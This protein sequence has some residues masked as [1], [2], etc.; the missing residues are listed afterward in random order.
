MEDQFGISGSVDC[1]RLLSFFPF[2][3]LRL[4]RVLKNKE[5]HNTGGW[6]WSTACF[7]TA[8]VSWMD[9]VSVASRRSSSVF[10]FF[11]FNTVFICR[12]HIIIVVVVTCR[13]FP[14][15]L[16]CFENTHQKKQACF[17]RAKKK[18]LLECCAVLHNFT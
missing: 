18:T 13:S 17:F 8:V 15:V 4:R 2:Y 9:G 3:C 5:Q 1:G 14:G 6:V 7:R 16:F 12:F 10:F 11:F